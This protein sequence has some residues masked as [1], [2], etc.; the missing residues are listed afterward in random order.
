MQAQKDKLNEH[1][2]ELATAV[3]ELDEEEKDRLHVQDQLT[4]IDKLISMRKKYIAALKERIKKLEGALERSDAS[5]SSKR[6]RE[7]Q[8]EQAEARKKQAGSVVARH[9][10]KQHDEEKTKALNRLADVAKDLPAFKPGEYTVISGDYTEVAKLIQ[11]KI[12]Q[13]IRAEMMSGNNRPGFMALA[14]YENE[15]RGGQGTDMPLPQDS[16]QLPT[17]Q[18]ENTTS[19]NPGYREEQKNKVAKNAEDQSAGGQQGNGKKAKPMTLFRMREIPQGPTIV[20]GNVWCNNKVGH[21]IRSCVMPNEFGFISGCFVC[22]QAHSPAECDVAKGLMQ[23]MPTMIQVP[24]I[25]LQV[26]FQDRRRKPPLEWNNVL[27]WAKAMPMAKDTLSKWKWVVV[28]GL[29]EV[30]LVWTLQFAKSVRNSDAVK[31]FDYA[32]GNVTGMPIDPL[33]FD[34]A[35]LISQEDSKF[36]ISPE[37]AQKARRVVV[38]EQGAG[39]GEIA[40]QSKLKKGEADVKVENDGASLSETPQEAA[41]GGMTSSANAAL[42]ATYNEKLEMLEAD[43]A[44]FKALLQGTSRRS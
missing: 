4:N 40:E 14:R 17:P 29:K 43:F 28:N 32:N 39:E 24:A 31:D 37:M 42:E 21:H 22:N 41:N 1:A 3:K 16:Q 20:C 9:P 34:G 38:E 6:K 11:T 7:D 33:T 5:S 19:Q 12:S 35:T 18:Y 2:A 26:F 23:K 10:D 27:D 44:E 36:E 13:G 15:G 8:P 30:G 25:F